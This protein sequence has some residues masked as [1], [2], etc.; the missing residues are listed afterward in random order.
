MSAATFT[1]LRDEIII[2]ITQASF[3]AFGFLFF[4]AKLFRDYEVKQT[5]VQLT[6]AGIFTLSCTMFE[7]I[8]FEIMDVLDRNSRWFNWKVDLWLMSIG[9]IVVI[10]FYQFYLFFSTCG[11]SRRLT[12]LASLT[13]LAGFVYGFWRIGDAFPIRA[14]TSWLSIEMFISRIG[15]VGVTMMAVLSGFG[16]V[17]CPYTYLSYFLRPVNDHHL[18]QLDKHLH[19]TVEKIVHK[20][21]RLVELQLEASRKAQQ[22]E[23]AGGGGGLINR[24][25]TQVVRSVVPGKDREPLLGKLLDGYRS[26][27]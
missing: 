11:L 22:A 13:L 20:K 5:L 12:W 6:F 23:G 16:A 26:T 4:K 18:V 9:V 15:V 24:L 19:Q 10:P 2:L 17:N 25:M 21:K 14:T 8:I 7:L 3:F 27:H 1:F